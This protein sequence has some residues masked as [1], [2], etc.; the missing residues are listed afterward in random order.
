MIWLEIYTLIGTTATTVTCSYTNQAG[1]SGRT[2]PAMTFGG[3]GLPLQQGDTGVR[4][5]QSVTVL[6]TTGTA[7]AFGVVLAKLIAQISNGQTGT[8]ETKDFLTGG[9][10]PI[11]IPAGSCLAY[12]FV[13]NSTAVPTPIIDLHIVETWAD[14]DN[15]LRRLFSDDDLE[16]RVYPHIKINH[17]AYSRRT[18]LGMVDN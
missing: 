9:S 17:Y 5:V 12:S 1:T 13:G 4:S 7:G 15:N 6:A 3:T 14:G 8:G 11:E 16:T 2:T 10:G 18:L